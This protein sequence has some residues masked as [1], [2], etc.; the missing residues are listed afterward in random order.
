MVSCLFHHLL[1]RRVLSPSLWPGP[2]FLLTHIPCCCLPMWTPKLSCS[3][4]LWGHLHTS[5]RRSHTHAYWPLSVTLMRELVLMA[6]ALPPFPAPSTQL[7]GCICFSLLGPS[8][9]LSRPRQ[10]CSKTWKLLHKYFLGTLHIFS[11]T[12]VW[13]T[14]QWKFRGSWNLRNHVTWFFKCWA[15]VF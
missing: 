12:L 14:K 7:L 1:M 15:K 5:Q 11:M 9:W 2:H 3:C 13:L 4:C 8:F 6:D 10:S